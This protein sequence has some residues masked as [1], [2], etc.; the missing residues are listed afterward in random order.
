MSDLRAAT[1]P[2]HQRLE[3]RIDLKATFATTSSYRAHTERMWGFY[4]P[5]EAASPRG[6]FG[7][8]LTDYATRHKAPLLERD[9]LALGADPSVFAVLPRC[10]FTPACNDPQA[11]FGCAYV[12]EGATLG[13]R[14][15]M[16]MVE[17]RLGLNATHG[18]AFLGSYGNAVDDMWR[19]FGRALDLC[20]SAGEQTETAPQRRLQP[21]SLRS[22]G[23]YA[24][25]TRDS[26]ERSS[27]GKP[28]SRPATGS[29]FIFRVRFSRTA[30]C[31]YWTAKPCI[32]EQVAGDVAACSPFTDV[33][34]H[35]HAPV[36]RA[37]RRR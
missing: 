4:V 22:N 1:W 23:G 14:T 9:I 11:A 13:G 35:R 28:T 33:E 15:L 8:W 21:R 32:I 34:V 25:R 10:P 30:S 27:S 7:D 37:G 6:V 29:R 3:K 5:L 36:R 19:S 24:T 18:A 31:W 26:Q 12:L 16:P 17:T 20:C 2:S